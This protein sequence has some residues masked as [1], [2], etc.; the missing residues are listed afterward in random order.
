MGVNETVNVSLSLVLGVGTLCFL[1]YWFGAHSFSYNTF[2]K[3]WIPDRIVDL[4]F[5][6]FQKALGILLI[7]IIPGA[8]W[9]TCRSVLKGRHGLS[10]IDPGLTLLWAI[11]FGAI[12]SVIPFFSARTNKMQA[13]YPQVK[14]TNW[15]I[16]L[17]LLNTLVWS[18]YLFAYEFLFRSFF[19]NNF[20]QSMD[21]LSAITLTTVLSVVTHM[22]KGATE[23]FGTIPFSILLCLAMVISGSI[24]AGFFIH[25]LLALSND[26]WAFY[27]NPKMRFNESLLVVNRHQIENRKSE[28]GA[29]NDLIP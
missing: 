7:G 9:Y 4:Y 2:L 28:H 1:L 19:L 22:P 10:M 3:K 5:P 16:R 29:T 25:L 13:F 11:G 20:L 15:G 21:T 12:M 17:I 26:Y 24:W 14:V 23:T 27:F 18:V 8:V 6:F